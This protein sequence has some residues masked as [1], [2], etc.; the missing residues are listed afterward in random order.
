MAQGDER[1]NPVAAMYREGYARADL[2]LRLPFHEPMNA[3]RR[4]L[5][6]PVVALPG[7]R[8]REEIAR[9]AGCDPAARWVLVGM[10]TV[11][12]SDSALDRLEALRDVVFLTVR[13][14]EW[15]RRNFRA[16]DPTSFPFADLVASADVVLS[17]PGYGIL[18][19]CVVNDRP[20]VCVER[21]DFP[22]ARVLVPAIRRYL[23]HAFVAQTDFYAGAI[24]SALKELREAPPPSARAPAGGAPIAARA[25][26]RL[27]N[28]A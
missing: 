1:W 27:A 8:R 28:E 22:E 5:D 19:E 25:L 18:S 10:G 11:G 6:V 17:K 7:R 3:F 13:P 2:L 4:R 14:L 21:D 12:W 9:A 23:R 24:E 16:F 26:M 15:R 20:L